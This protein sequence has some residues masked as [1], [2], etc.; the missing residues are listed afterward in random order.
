MCSCFPVDVVEGERDEVGYRGA[1]HVVVCWKLYFAPRGEAWHGAA[2]RRVRR[3]EVGREVDDDDEFRLSI[4]D[5]V[6]WW[7]R[8]RKLMGR[9]ADGGWV[10]GGVQGWH[11]Q[12]SWL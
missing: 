10:V 5:G 3:V 2:V 12:Q 11:W 8:G 7:F 1:N 9:D 4:G 6:S